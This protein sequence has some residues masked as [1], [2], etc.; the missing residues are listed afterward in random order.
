MNERDDL[1]RRLQQTI[2]DKDML[3]SRYTVDKEKMKEK[4]QSKIAA[5]KEKL[6]REMKQK[7]CKER[8]NYQVSW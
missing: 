5:A 2:D 3:I 8:D 7:V 6:A 1:I 4:C